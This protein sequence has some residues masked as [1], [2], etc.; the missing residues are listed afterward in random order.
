MDVVHPLFYS[1]MYCS[2]DRDNDMRRRFENCNG[3]QRVIA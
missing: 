2:G 3:L 1:K